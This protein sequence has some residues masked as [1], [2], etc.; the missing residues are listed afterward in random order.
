MAKKNSVRYECSNCGAIAA[1]WSGRCHVCGEWNTLQEQ[2]VVEP[3]NI[4]RQGTILK[5]QPITTVTKTERIK[6]LTTE[7]SEV[8][9]VL[10]GGSGAASGGDVDDGSDFLAGCLSVPDR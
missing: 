8:D 6:R 1:T 2:L 4:A 5:P 3:G 10:G 7:I 9:S